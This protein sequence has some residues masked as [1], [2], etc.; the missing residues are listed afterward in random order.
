MPASDTSW[1]GDQE[2]KRDGK[3]HIDGRAQWKRALRE[4]RLAGAPTVQK[5][6]P[7]KSLCSKRRDSIAQDYRS[8]H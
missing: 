4:V 6:G 5:E 3:E 2:N 8:S 7:P 1:Q